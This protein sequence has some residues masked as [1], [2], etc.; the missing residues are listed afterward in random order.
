MDELKWKELEINFLI[1][2]KFLFLN[3]TNKNTSIYVKLHKL[4]ILTFISNKIDFF[5]KKKTVSLY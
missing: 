4:Y 5:K 1:I 3:K 2:S